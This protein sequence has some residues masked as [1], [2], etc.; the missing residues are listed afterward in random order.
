MVDKNFDTYTKVV[1]VTNTN[2]KGTNIQDILP[3][4]SEGGRLILIRDFGNPY[5]ENAIKVY[6]HTK[7]ESIHIGYLTR[8]L[9]A[10]LSEFLDENPTFDIDG[11]VDEI[12]GGNGKTYGC[13]IQIWIQ[14]PD[15][16][17]YDEIKAFQETLKHPTEYEDI[18]SHSPIVNEPHK[19]DSNSNFELI[20]D[21]IVYV[22]VAIFVGVLCFGLLGKIWWLFYIIGVGAF[23]FAAYMLSLIIKISKK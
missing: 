15:E 23:A 4:L 5:D 22:L 16:P 7:K 20:A 2:D 3:L 6:Y 9:A 10:N 8:E 21:S 19:Q 13:N 14:D 1:G 18:S 11:I 12:T 17:S